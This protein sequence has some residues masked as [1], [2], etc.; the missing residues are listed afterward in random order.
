MVTD[1]I[2][3]NSPIL[4]ITFNDNGLNAPIKNKD[5]HSESKNKT[6]SYVMYKNLTLNI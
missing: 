1:T 4:V 5:Y 2:A 3:I 6:Q